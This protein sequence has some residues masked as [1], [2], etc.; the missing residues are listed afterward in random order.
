MKSSDINKQIKFRMSYHPRKEPDGGKK[1][2]YNRRVS[3]ARPSVL[4]GAFQW[5]RR[6]LALA[7]GV[8]YLTPVSVRLVGGSVGT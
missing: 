1:K 3:A 5:R 8:P 7:I 2:R 4:L 6:L